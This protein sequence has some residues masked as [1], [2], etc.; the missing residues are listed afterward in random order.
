MDADEEYAVDVVK[1]DGAIMR[2]Y[3][4]EKYE[5]KMFAEVVN[6]VDNNFLTALLKRAYTGD[7]E[8]TT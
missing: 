6:I 7:Y 4:D 8:I 5:A 2:F 3:F 1:S